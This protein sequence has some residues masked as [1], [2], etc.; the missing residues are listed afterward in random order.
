MQVGV[1][2]CT[3]ARPLHVYRL[4]DDSE[5][6]Y[7]Y[8]LVHYRYVIIADILLLNSLRVGI[9]A[10]LPE[11][12]RRFPVE[13]ASRVHSCERGWSLTFDVGVVTTCTL[14]HDAREGALCHLIRYFLFQYLCTITTNVGL[15]NNM[16][17]SVY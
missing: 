16:N 15:T 6:V 7:C 11:F 13:V 17:K 8:H 1:A 10:P 9:E 12:T 5:A 14:S 3:K 2:Y 4:S